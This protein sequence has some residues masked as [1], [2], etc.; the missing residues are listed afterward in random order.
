MELPGASGGRGGPGEGGAMASE[1]GAGPRQRLGRRLGLEPYYTVAERGPGRLRL[2]SRPEANRG[3]GQRIVAGGLALLAVAALIIFSAVIAVVGG[4]GFAPGAL[5]A[6]L[7]GLL[8]AFGYQRAYGGYA[9]LTTRN[10]VV[11]D[12]A[13]AAVTFTQGNRVAPER[14]QRL[15]FAQIGALRLRRRS[16]LAGALVRRETPV[17]AL[18]LVAAYGEVW[19]VDSAADPELLRD[20][21]EGLSAVLGMELARG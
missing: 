5:G 7:G 13:D 11:A 17:V 12:A 3:P 21:A 10:A 2:E 16:Y 20:A 1:S 6:V 15:A 4:M 8:G 18:E 19:I 14:T 9:V